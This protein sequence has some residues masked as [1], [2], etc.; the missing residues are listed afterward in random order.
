MS[1]AEFKAQGE[2]YLY[3]GRYSSRAWQAKFGCHPTICSVIW[4][5]YQRSK[6]CVAE[7]S[8]IHLLWLLHWLK[9]YPTWEEFESSMKVNRK[10][11]KK[12]MFMLLLY[13]FLMFMET[14][15]V[16]LYLYLL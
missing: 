11:A 4:R 10:V 16:L 9:T 13:F 2:V 15:I 8:S 6:Y 3:D 1:V 12:S 14:S 5:L 7:C